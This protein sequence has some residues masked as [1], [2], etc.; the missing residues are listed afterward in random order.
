MGK[1]VIINKETE[2]FGHGI[3]YGGV[4]VFGVEGKSLRVDFCVVNC[5]MDGDITWVHC[6]S[7]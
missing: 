1:Q 6:S 7:S 5:L 2:D 3:S 4:M